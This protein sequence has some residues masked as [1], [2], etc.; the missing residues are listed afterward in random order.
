MLAPE[1]R[2]PSGSRLLERRWCE[3]RFVILTGISHL[4]RGR[5]RQSRCALRS[6]SPSHANPVLQVRQDFAR[7]LTIVT[8]V[9]PATSLSAQ[10]LLRRR[11]GGPFHVQGVVYVS[12]HPPPS[13]RLV[14]VS[15]AFDAFSVPRG[16]RFRDRRWC[17]PPAHV[18]PRL[19]AARGHSRNCT[20]PAKAGE[21]GS[22]ILAKARRYPRSRRTERMQW[23]GRPGGTICEYDIRRLMLLLNA[24]AAPFLMAGGTSFRVMKRIR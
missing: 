20:V 19:R 17:R 21:D 4:G 3:R 15:R 7:I 24:V 1:P 23:S 12:H 6:S 22:R 10:A 16:K 8:G 5:F 9:M 14:A 11:F 2:L 13:R 18:A